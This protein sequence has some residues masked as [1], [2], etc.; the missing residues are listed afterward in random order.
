[1]AFFILAVLLTIVILKQKLNILPNSQ[2]FRK[3]LSYNSVEIKKILLEFF[4]FSGFGENSDFTTNVKYEIPI[5][6]K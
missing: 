3:V 6:P 1:M 4:Y 5:S 2:F